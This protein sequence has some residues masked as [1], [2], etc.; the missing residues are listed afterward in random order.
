S[1]MK[2]THTAYAQLL[3]FG[4]GVVAETGSV[5]QSLRRSRVMLVTTEGRHSSPAGQRIVRS[6]GPAL[7]SIFTGVRPHVPTT[8]VQA[9]VQ[10]AKKDAVDC[11]VSFGGGASADLGKAICFHVDHDAGLKDATY[12]DRA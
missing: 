5:V 6:L 11:I 7:V 2:F 3:R 8:V 10:Q 12:F 1:P 4:C 9:A